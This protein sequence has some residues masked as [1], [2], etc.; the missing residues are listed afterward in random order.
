VNDESPAALRR[1]R[2]ASRLLD[3]A[4]RIPGTGRRVGLDPV[5]GLLPIAGDVLGLAL[6]LYTVAEAARLGVPRR[7][8]A[9]MLVNAGVD[10]AGGSIP[11]AGI[12]VDAAWKANAR[13]VALIERHLEE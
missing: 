13:N 4:V 11:V 9:R 10:A 7:L 3:D 8:L 2:F 6:S 12:L 5:V 1:V